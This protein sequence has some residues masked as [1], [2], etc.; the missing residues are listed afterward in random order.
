M[1]LRHARSDV[2]VPDGTPLPEAL[3][4]TTHLA[5]AAHQ[6][7]VEI[8]AA[9][10]ILE[11]F[12]ARER[13]L[14]AVVATDGA[15]SSRSGPYASYTDEAMRDVRRLEQRKAAAIGNYGAALQLAYTSAQVKDAAP[16]LVADLTDVLEATR[17]EVVFTHNPADRHDTHVA[18]ALRVLE[19]CRAL[20]AEARP[21]RLLGGEVWRDLDWLVDG[22]KVVLDVS[23][24]EGLQAALLG[25][26]DSQV[27]GGKRYDLATLG[28]RRAHAT[29]H[30]SHETD[31]ATGL[32]FAMDLT[33]LV[34]DPGL[35][36]GAFVQERLDRFAAD[37]GERLSRLA[38]PRGRAR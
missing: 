25:V 13:W 2:Y 28:R 19:A 26:F 32:A 30:A 23:A 11:C 27:A 33:P 5:V 24:R 3:A 9:S 38:D 4:R 37:V 1:R 34:H 16:D 31:A 17:P 35:E 8:L 36:P 10:A 15:G 20:P 18:T 29:Y 6:D 21:G 7:D 22:D 12:D 14:T